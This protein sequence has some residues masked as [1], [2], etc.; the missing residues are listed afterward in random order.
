MFTACKTHG[1][2]AI[3]TRKKNDIQFL[4]HVKPMDEIFMKIW[5]FPQLSSQGP[6]FL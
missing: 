5:D 4:H 6:L 2:L 1:Y 3:I